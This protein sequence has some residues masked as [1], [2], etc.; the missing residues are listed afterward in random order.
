MKKLFTLMLLCTA[1]SL[2]FLSCSKN[3]DEEVLLSIDNELRDSYFG[4]LD[5]FYGYNSN[6][7][8]T[9]FCIDANNNYL[10]NALA[11]TTDGTQ[12]YFIATIK[13]K[14]TV[15]YF[16]DSLTGQSY[17]SWYSP[18]EIGEVQVYEG[19]GVYRSDTLGWQIFH[20]GYKNYQQSYLILL[21][22]IFGINSSIR[23]HLFTGIIPF[24][25]LYQYINSSS[26]TLLFFCNQEKVNKVIQIPW[27]SERAFWGSFNN[28]CFVDSCCYDITSGDSI[29]KCISLPPSNSFES[30]M[31]GLW[32]SNNE[33]I[34]AKGRS[35]YKQNLQY[36][37]KDWIT[38]VPNLENEP[39]DDKISYEIFQQT[40]LYVQ[41]MVN[42][43]RYDG[44]TSNFTFK[45]S[46]E[47]GD[48]IQ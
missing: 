39:S 44:T 35:I 24:N 45:V 4:Q 29:Y 40:E 16:C 41:Y 2:C 32:L 21:D 23:D 6:I 30:E 27:K 38:S 1:I 43:I 15:F 14:H 7:I 46:I 36:S 22:Q 20:G 3:E 9:I 10:Y 31:S 48:I 12:K 26:R 33:I 5:G 47:S 8:P 17:C 18:E 37:G 34:Y 25:S 13:D 28:S 42:I 11:Y 19:Y